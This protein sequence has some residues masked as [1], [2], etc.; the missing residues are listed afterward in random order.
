MSK[1]KKRNIKKI[2][3]KLIFNLY[4]NFSKHPMHI[5]KIMPFPRD[6]RCL[7]FP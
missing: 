6:Q 1:K 7:R 4:N 2:G 5:H 3:K